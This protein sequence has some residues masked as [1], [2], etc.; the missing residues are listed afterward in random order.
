[1]VGVLEPNRAVWNFCFQG[2]FTFL[3]PHLNVFT[4][5]FKSAMFV[6]RLLTLVRSI[7]L[8][9]L[10]LSVQ[11]KVEVVVLD[12]DEDELLSYMP[13]HHH[14]LAKIAAHQ[15]HETAVGT[16]EQS[17]LHCIE[18]FVQWC[19]P[20]RDRLSPFSSQPSNCQAPTPGMHSPLAVLLY[21]PSLAPSGPK[22]QW[23]CAQ[24]SSRVQV[25]LHPFKPWTVHRSK[26]KLHR[27]IDRQTEPAALTQGSI[28]TFVPAT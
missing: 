3:A 20:F 25:C 2:F 4:W 17:L 12:V 6:S 14:V 11:V 5:H 13:S 26:I 1:M 18:L 24:C 16:Q 9:R 27:E 23:A 28:P 22:V 21:V 10:H 15:H 8:C 19:L 7:V